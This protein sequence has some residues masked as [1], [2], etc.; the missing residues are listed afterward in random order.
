MASTIK[1]TASWK[2]GMHTDVQGGGHTIIID[3]PESAGGKNEG[4]DPLIIFLSSLGGCLA[5]IAAIIARQERLEIRK[6]DVEVEGDIDKAFLL[7]KTKEGRAGFT[8]IRAKVNLDAD[9]TVEEKEAFLERVDSRC[10]I[11]DN[12]ANSTKIVISLE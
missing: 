1:L 10:P 3:Q 5:T 7:G 4:P 2:G 11:S 8:E 9:M 12:T 6:I